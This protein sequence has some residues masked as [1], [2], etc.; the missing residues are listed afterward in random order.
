MREVLIV[1]D[2]DHIRDVVRFALEKEGFVTREAGDGAEALSCFQ[3][4]GADLVILDIKM[5]GMDG[6]EVCR[7]LR[8]ETTAP[9]LFLS[10]KDEEID[11]IIG[12]EMGGDDYVTKPFSPRELVAR[13]K[14]ILRRLE[15]RPEEIPAGDQRHGKLRLD[16]ER[17]KTYW[18][19]KEVILTATEFNLLRTM[20]SRPGNVYTR[21]ALMNG[22]YLKGQIVSDRTIDSHI[23]RLRAKFN[24]LGGDP[25]ET[26]HGVGYRLGES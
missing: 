7:C 14:A 6:L 17:Y 13:V 11:R 16:T 20:L 3:A 23:R 26:V 9:I 24:Y 8:R 10:S 19:G 21:D 22:A 2:D 12:L 18:D 15:R 4:Q 1:D 5:P 25:I